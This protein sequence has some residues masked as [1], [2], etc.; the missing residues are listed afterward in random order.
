MIDTNTLV[1]LSQPDA[2][3]QS[4]LAFC[5]MVNCMTTINGILTFRLMPQNA[6]YGFY[7]LHAHFFIRIAFD[8]TTLQNM[9]SLG[10]ESNV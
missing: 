2:F 5:F 8:V 3:Q 7:L 10:S 6:R 4:L 1:N 9:K